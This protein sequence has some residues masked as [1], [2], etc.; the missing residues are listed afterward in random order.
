MADTQFHIISKTVTKLKFY[1]IFYQY[2]L[3]DVY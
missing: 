3:Y 2:L 1:F